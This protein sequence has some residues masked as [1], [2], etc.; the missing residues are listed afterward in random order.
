MLEKKV[1]KFFSLSGGSAT[2]K[3]TFLLYVKI[4]LVIPGYSEA[5]ASCSDLSSGLDENVSLITSS[6]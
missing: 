1:L 3:L 4:V 6:I 2:A 5:G